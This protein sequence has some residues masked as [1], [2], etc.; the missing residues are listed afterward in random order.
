MFEELLSSRPEPLLQ[1]AAEHPDRYD[2]RALSLIRA[3]YNNSTS[4]EELLPEEQ[5]LVDQAT[6]EFFQ[7]PSP[8]KPESKKHSTH[9]SPIHHHEPPK[10]EPID[11][12]VTDAFWWT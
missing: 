9:S 7:A 2:E 3:I 11:G 4:Y 12:P 6:T 10:E 1:S 5:V 8:K